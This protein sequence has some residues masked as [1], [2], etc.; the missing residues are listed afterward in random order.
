MGGFGIDID[1][2]VV[3]VIACNLNVDAKKLKITSKTQGIFY[4]VLGNFLL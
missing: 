1:K 4:T 2:N 3:D